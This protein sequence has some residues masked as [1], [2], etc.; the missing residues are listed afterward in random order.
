MEKIALILAIIIGFTF[1]NICCYTHK[2]EEIISSAT[3]KNTNSETNS[4]GAYLAGRVAHIRHDLNT[5]ADYYM[6]VIDKLPSDTIL[7]NQLYIML[8]S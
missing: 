2:P 5:S 7:I 1:S 4:Y 6:K 3:I 8:T